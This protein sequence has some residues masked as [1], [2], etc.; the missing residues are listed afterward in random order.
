MELEGSAAHQ[1]IKKGTVSRN[2]PRVV[3]SQTCFKRR[4]VRGDSRRHGS[5]CI[6]TKSP[7][8]LKEGVVNASNLGIP[9]GHLPP[10]RFGT[11]DEHK[12]LT[13]SVLYASHCR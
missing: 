9:A 1:E 10:S 7:N 6:Q 2:A 13:S 5:T 4:G 3:T 12:G 11:S 8:A